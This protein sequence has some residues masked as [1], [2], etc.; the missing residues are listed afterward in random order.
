MKRT[1]SSL[2]SLFLFS[3][4]DSLALF[5]ASSKRLESS[6]PSAT[7]KLQAAAIQS[8]WWKRMEELADYRNKHGDTLVPKRYPDNP[9]LGN[10]VNKQRQ[11][12]RKFC[13]KESPCSLTEEKVRILN[14]I[15]FCWDATDQALMVQ[16]QEDAWWARFEDLKACGASLS[17]SK[18]PSSL[19]SFLRQQRIEFQQYKK[20]EPSKLDKAKVAALESFDPDWYKSHHERQ[21]DER[22]KELEEYIAKYGNCCVPI[23]YENKKLATWVSNVRKRYKSS[24]NNRTG[25]SSA[26]SPKQTDQLNALGFVWDIWDYEFEHKYSERG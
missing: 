1:T 14:E 5:S 16:R 22:C 24:S 3:R 6:I 12:Y 9:A 4:A 7:T 19:V 2:L 13:A 25:Q 11:N 23:N 26:L 20:G 8:T 21:W 17:Q 10:F 15:G 18:L